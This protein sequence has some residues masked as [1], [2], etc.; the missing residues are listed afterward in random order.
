MEN[1][2]LAE[3]LT[4]HTRDGARSLLE[5][6]QASWLWTRLRDGFP[7]AFSF[8]IM[9]NHLHLVAPPGGRARFVR[10]LAMFTARFNVRFDVIVETA[11]S[12]DIAIRMIRYGFLNP[13]SDGLIRDP[14][15]WRWSTL[16]DLIGAAHPI[17][18]RAPVVAAALG[19][20]EEALVRRVTHSADLRPRRPELAAAPLATMPT[21]HEAT[22]SALR[23]A[24][25]EVVKH[26]LGRQLLVQ[27][28]HA[29][30]MPV[31][32]MLAAELGR[33][34]R[35]IRRDRKRSHPALSAVLLCLADARLR[36]AAAP[37]P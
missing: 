18:T 25:H 1:G 20:K 33:S 27:A 26:V 28:A 31:P 16:R 3:H 11:N 32:A 4:A 22:A 29:V 8:E 35:T 23:I 7:D 36:H 19:V 6:A 17:W 5:H 9:P 37:R 30:G 14:Y 15:A 13:V 2:M 21:L 12:A 34:G 24:D 10:V